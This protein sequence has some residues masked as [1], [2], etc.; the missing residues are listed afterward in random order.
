[1]AVLWTATTGRRA[2]LWMKYAGFCSRAKSV[3]QSSLRHNR[4]LACLTD[5]ATMNRWAICIWNWAIM[6]GK[7]LATAGRLILDKVWHL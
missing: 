1:M 5:S 2:G 7:R 6:K 3:K 4:W